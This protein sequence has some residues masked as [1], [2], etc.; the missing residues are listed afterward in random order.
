MLLLHDKKISSRLNINIKSIDKD[1][2][3]LPNGEFR[4][5]LEANSINFDLKSEQERDVI[6]ENYQSLLNSLPCPI[7]IVVRIRS[8]N[9]DNYIENFT[10]RNVLSAQIYKKQ[11]NN[12]KTFVKDLIKQNKIL[13]RRFYL[14]IPFNKTDQKENIEENL[15]L[16]CDI[17]NNNFA[18]LGIQTKRLNSLEIIDLFYSFYNP[19]KAKKQP[20]VNQ[21]LKLMKEAYL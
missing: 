18:K 4:A 15:N 7:Q 11:T 16:Y 2:L 8:L 21:T 9:I 19:E 3:E 14:I 1:I 5:I 10:L 6:I 20:V 12:Y 13:T 17:I